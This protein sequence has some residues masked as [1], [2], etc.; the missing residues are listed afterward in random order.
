MAPNTEEEREFQLEVLKIQTKHQD[1]LTLS[2]WLMAIEFSIFIPIA[3]TYLSYGL[4][5]KNDWYVYVSVMWLL[6][7]IIIYQLTVRYFNSSRIQQQIDN[8]VEKELKPI[9]E[10]YINKK[11]QSDV[12]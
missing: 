1:I 7:L 3:V 6:A 12:K 2:T 5:V 8:N 10:K 9:R 11:D 4:T